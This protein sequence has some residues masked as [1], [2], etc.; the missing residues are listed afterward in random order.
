MKNWAALSCCSAIMFTLTNFC[1]QDMNSIGLEAIFYYGTGGLILSSVYYINYYLKFDYENKD[2]Y[3]H[4]TGKRR[5]VWT[6]PDGKIDWACVRAYC[7]AACFQF[8]IA[9]SVTF[10][11]IL[12]KKAHLN[13]GIPTAI[14]AV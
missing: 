10:I 4:V 13:V 11:F 12:A 6:N 7:V 9:F 2:L 8:T 14:W 3:S 1:W 5:Y